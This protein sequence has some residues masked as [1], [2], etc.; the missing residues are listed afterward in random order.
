[1]CYKNSLAL[2][3]VTDFMMLFFHPGTLDSYKVL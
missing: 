3:H 1:M 2:N